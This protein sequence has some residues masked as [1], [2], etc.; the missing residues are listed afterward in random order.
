MVKDRIPPIR[1]NFIEIG[2]SEVFCLFGSLLSKGISTL[3][4]KCQKDSYQKDEELT[5]LNHIDNT[6]SGSDVKC[7]EVKLHRIVR[8]HSLTQ[9]QS[10]G[11]DVI[12][13]QEVART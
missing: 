9:T 2:Q 12:V 11:Y 1:K 7:V 6:R 8:L 4:V 3:K 10:S 13:K 5:I